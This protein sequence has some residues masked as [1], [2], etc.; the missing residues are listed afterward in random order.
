MQN[1]DKKNST[2][3]NQPLVLEIIGF[4]LT[5][6]VGSWLTYYFNQ[7]SWKNK[8]NFEIH[9]ETLKEAI[10]VEEDILSSA[11][12]RIYNL[13]RINTKL[14]NNR[15]SD[16]KKIWDKYYKTVE[17]WNINIKINEYK[18][19]YLFGEKISLLFLDNNEN[20]ISNP[21]SL[22]HVIRKTHNSVNDFR[23][24]KK[25]REPCKK[26]EQDSKEKLRILKNT[27]NEFSK[28][29]YKSIN[30]KKKLFRLNNEN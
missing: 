20:N 19:K 13:N 25:K 16:V 1:K 8:T 9:K 10:Q 17:E 7:I 12:K 2:F 28:V 21:K 4:I 5:I 29:L 30:E 24:C 15:L 11:K 6:I 18:V 3:W 22:H 23:K 26:K 27:Y 14:E